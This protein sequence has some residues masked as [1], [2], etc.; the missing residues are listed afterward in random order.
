MTFFDGDFFG[1]S[2]GST[3]PTWTV[4]HASD[5]VATRDTYSM[6]DSVPVD[7]GDEIRVRAS[8]NANHVGVLNGVTYSFALPAGV[9]DGSNGRLQFR[10]TLAAPFATPW[11]ASFGIYD[12]VASMALSAGAR[13]VNS[14]SKMRPIALRTTTQVDGVDCTAT[15][16]DIVGVVEPRGA[17]DGVA[18][19]GGYVGAV[20]QE[21]DLA[22]GACDGGGSTTPTT[23]N[24]RLVLCLSHVNSGNTDVLD[25]NIKVEYIVSAVIE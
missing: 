18:A 14:T 5:I 10:L 15:A 25:H 1:R 4:L 6:E 20:I 7:V 21:G 13:W 22:T 23:A 12:S 24:T 16:T 2:N 9:C 8:T 3:A 17:F 11:G 19:F